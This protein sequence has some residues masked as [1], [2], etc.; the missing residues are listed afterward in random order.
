MLLAPRRRISAQCFSAM[1]VAAAALFAAAAVSA[2]AASAAAPGDVDLLVASDGGGN[3]TSV[4]SALD[5]LAPGAHPGLGH[6]RLRL[7]GV[8]RERVYIYS[9]FTRGVRVEAAAGAAARPL[10]IFNVSAN[11][12]ATCAATGGPGGL[13]AQTLQIDADDVTVS[14]IDIANSACGYDAKVA[15]QSP[16]LNLGRSDRAAFYGVGL[17][18]AQDTL[19][20]GNGRS[21]WSNLWINGTCDAIFGSSTAVFQNATIVMD[22]AATAHRGNGTN[23]YL[24]LDSRV[25]TLSGGPGTLDLGRP[26]GSLAHVVWVR[27][28]MGA[29]VSKEGWSDWSHNCSVPGGG[30]CNATFYAEHA[31][32]GPGADPAGRVSWSYQLNA[33]E[34]ARWTPAAL[35][36]DW[37]PPAW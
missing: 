14:G 36:G 8:F 9:N 11:G 23:A 26:W 31:S 27:T 35:L 29:G 32:Y 3:F 7:R 17:F 15:G 37:T 5:W 10:L 16:A 33:S 24:F 28:Y 25:D 2:S 4:Q 30:W 18:G 19:F 6:V 21:Y 13:E 1:R 34:A 20:T 22:F 12:G